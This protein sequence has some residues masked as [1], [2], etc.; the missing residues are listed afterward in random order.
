[1]AEP[2]G[3]SSPFSGKVWVADLT[4]PSIALAERLDKGVDGDLPRELIAYVVQTTSDAGK[5][6]LLP[7]DRAELRFLYWHDPITLSG[8]TPCRTNASHP[9]S[10]LTFATG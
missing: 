1:M 3:R 7:V 9:G 2:L 8:S 6:P 10:S 4:N 5:R